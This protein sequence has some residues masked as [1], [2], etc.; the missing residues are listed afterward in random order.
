M[1][2]TLSVTTTSTGETTA[3]AQTTKATVDRP[4]T[5]NQAACKTRT[6][7]DW[8][9]CRSHLP[10]TRPSSTVTDDVPPMDCGVTPPAYSRRSACRRL[11]TNISTDFQVDPNKA[12]ALSILWRDSPR[13]TDIYYSPSTSAATRRTILMEMMDAPSQKRRTY[14]QFIYIKH[15]GGRLVLKFCLNAMHY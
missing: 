10:D 7:V 4:Q 5:A 6:T 1:T 3:A 2:A 13:I 8:R 14:I 12:D 9:P 15:Y 11:S